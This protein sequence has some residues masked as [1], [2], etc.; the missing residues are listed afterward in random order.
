MNDSKYGN[1][2]RKWIGK[3]TQNEGEENTNE[4]MEL[5]FN[6]VADCFPERRAGE[7]CWETF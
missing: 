2:D 1:I 3:K 4:I 6:V 5:S 7:S